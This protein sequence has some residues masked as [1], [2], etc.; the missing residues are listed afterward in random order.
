MHPPCRRILLGQE[1]ES[2][3]WDQA[4]KLGLKGQGA[5]LVGRQEQAVAR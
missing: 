5:E 1:P 3:P 2:E 4:Q